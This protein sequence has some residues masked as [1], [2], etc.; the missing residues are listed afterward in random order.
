[1]SICDCGNTLNFYCEILESICTNCVDKKVNEIISNKTYSSD[2]KLFLTKVLSKFTCCHHYYNKIN[3]VDI[4]IE[5]VNN[6]LYDLY[7]L[8]HLLQTLDC[9]EYIDSD[10]F[11]SCINNVIQKLS[12]ETIEILFHYKYTMSHN[13]INYD[14]YVS[15]NVLKYFINNSII[16][17]IS[18]IPYDDIYDKDKTMNKMNTFHTY[19]KIKKSFN[20]NEIK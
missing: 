16:I 12:Y 9:E 18:R 13:I 11:W 4:I 14:M 20:E 17:D 1:M 15:S 10:E 6:N 7:E 8:N 3:D 2:D 5:S 19:L